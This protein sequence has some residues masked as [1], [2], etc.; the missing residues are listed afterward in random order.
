MSCKGCKL[1]EKQY[2][3]ISEMLVSTPP[4]M[5]APTKNIFYIDIKNAKTDDSGK[6]IVNF[7]INGLNTR[8]IK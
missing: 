4:F 3:S 6:I 5:A 1:C 2:L 7:K 8:G